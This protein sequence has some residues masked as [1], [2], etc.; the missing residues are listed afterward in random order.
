M[1]KGSIITLVNIAFIIGWSTALYKAKLD[2]E[3]A[4]PYYRECILESINK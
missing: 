2:V 3:D 1:N 4:F